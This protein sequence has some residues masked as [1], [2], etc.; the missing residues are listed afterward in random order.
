MSDGVFSGEVFVSNPFVIAI[1]GCFV[2]TAVYVLF[3]SFKFRRETARLR[4][5]LVDSNGVDIQGT[6]LTT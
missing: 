6:S 5:K 1:V 3:L 2:V 4:D